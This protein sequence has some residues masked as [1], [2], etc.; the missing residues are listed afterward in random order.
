MGR[1]PTRVLGRCA[2][3]A[4]RTAAHESG[5]DTS[6]VGARRGRIVGARDG[7]A[8]VMTRPAAVIAAPLA[9]AAVVLGGCGGGSQPTAS[10]AGRPVATTGGTTS[11]SPATPAVTGRVAWPQRKL[12]R[13]LH[14]R[15][16][17]VEG[18][19]VAVDRSTITCGG[20]GRAQR[21]DHTLAWTGFHCVQLTFPAGAVAGP[22]AVFDVYPTGPRTLHIAAARFARY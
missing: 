11:A 7:D 3:A 2:R 22:D 10:T 17:Y 4:R 15:I 20:V 12:V 6:A 16:I 5:R 14:G 1:P 9:A 21:R 8:D 13:R 18:R 19:R